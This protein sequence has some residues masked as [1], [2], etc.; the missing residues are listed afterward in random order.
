MKAIY[1][2]HWDVGR[3]GNL[4]GLFIAEKDDVEKIIGSHIYFGEVLGKHS[5]VYGDLNEEDLEMKTDDQEFISKLQKILN[6]ESTIS[7]YNPFDYYEEED[8]DEE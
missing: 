4:N 2:F 6:V 1:K 7:G 8:E 3:M 5:E